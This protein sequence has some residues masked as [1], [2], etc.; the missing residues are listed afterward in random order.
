VIGIYICDTGN[1]TIRF[2]DLIQGKVSTLVK[3]RTLFERPWAI[4]M[5]PPKE[6]DQETFQFCIGD[7]PSMRL[8]EPYEPV[9]FSLAETTVPTPEL[10]FTSLPSSQ[11]TKTL[12]PLWSYSR[13]PFPFKSSSLIARTLIGSMDNEV[14]AEGEKMKIKIYSPASNT[15]SVCK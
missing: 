7:Q 15:S 2:L 12:Y 14:S 4:S 9:T 3:N 6:N 8:G 5:V 10:S 13:T 1:R 11:R